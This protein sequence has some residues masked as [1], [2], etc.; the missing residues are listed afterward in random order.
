MVTLNLPS[1]LKFPSVFLN[2]IGTLGKNFE[3][4]FHRDD[5]A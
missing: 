3:L 5:G 2:C 4:F 1:F